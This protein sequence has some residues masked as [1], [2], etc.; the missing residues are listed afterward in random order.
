MKKI[1]MSPEMDVIE[2]KHQQTLLAGSAV[3]NVEDTAIPAENVDAPL[4]GDDDMVVFED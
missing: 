2:L 4:F 3:F 1:Y